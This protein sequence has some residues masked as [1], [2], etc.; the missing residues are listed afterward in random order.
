MK[1]IST[2]VT[3]ISIGGVLLKTERVAEGFVLDVEDGF[4]HIGVLL[5]HGFK[6]FEESVGISRR[7][8]ATGA[9]TG[10]EQTSGAPAGAPGAPSGPSGGAEKKD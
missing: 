9:N 10:T 7:G 1:F 5:S 8:V 6:V 2:N 4:K 3:S